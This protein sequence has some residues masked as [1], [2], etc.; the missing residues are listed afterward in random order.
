MQEIKNVNSLE[1]LSVGRAFLKYLIPSLL[2]MLIMGANFII[3]GIM[4][5]NKL[6]AVALA[7]VGIAGPAYTLFA[8]M[9][10]WI[11]IGGATLYSQAMGEKDYTKA[12]Q[13]FSQSLT[14]IFV[15]TLFIGIT[16]Y[17]F[18][19]PLVYA[20]GAN[21]ETYP[22]AFA[23][24]Q[25]MLLFGFIITVE[26]ALS[27]FVRNDGNPN[28]AM[29]AQIAFALS[30]VVFNSIA[31]YVLDAGV[32]GVAIGTMS[33]AFVGLLVLSAH[34]FKKNTYLKF[35][36]F[37]WNKKMLW[38]IFLIGFPSFIAEVGMSVFTVAHNVVLENLA[39]TA[40]V[41]AFSTLNYLHGVM[42]MAFLGLGSAIQP[43]I[44]YY[45]GAQ[46]EE[47][48]RQTVRIAIKTAL[49][50]GVGLLLV[51]QFWAA[52]IVG[53]FGDFPAE[54]TDLAVTGLKVFSLAYLF[55]GVNFVMM[56][57]FQSINHVKMAIWVTAA[58]EIILMLIFLAVLPSFFGIQGVWS[59]VP[60][61]EG[62]VVVTIY[63]YYNKYFVRTSLLREN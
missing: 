52:P 17:L 9:S 35:R 13:I 60:L 18:K 4:V 6:G 14:V 41:A 8:A 36:K 53:I 12:K 56:T 33:A 22:H 3:D 10:L 32:Q 16:A 28:L 19:E 26:S 2:G 34:F 49:G 54:V 58:R 30:N 47:R 20:L 57:Y 25:I 29:A 39:G 38:A 63:L 11:G 5:G 59:A 55:I 24:L 43:L 21:E 45:H 37:K 61:S 31:L 62:I 48:K 27:I 50:I 51:I 40:G 42:L 23:Y 15:A 7:G 46:Q 44:S 1:S